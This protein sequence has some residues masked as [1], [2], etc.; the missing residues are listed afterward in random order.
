MMSSAGVRGRPAAP[1]G[2]KPVTPD[3]KTLPDGIG[4]GATC[5]LVVVSHNC[6]GVWTARG[7]Y[8]MYILKVQHLP[9]V[10]ALP[11]HNRSLDS[12]LAIDYVGYEDV[13]TFKKAMGRVMLESGEWPQDAVYEAS[14]VPPI[15]GFYADNL[16]LWSAGVSPQFAAAVAQVMVDIVV[17]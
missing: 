6:A 11:A 13:D 7:L 4:G 1:A 15:C 14:N 5:D 10:F 16:T 8:E 9:D 3:G 12:L 17:N 2:C